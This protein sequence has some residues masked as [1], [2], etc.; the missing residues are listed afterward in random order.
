MLFRPADNAARMREGASRMS[1]VAPDENLFIKGVV[2]AVLENADMVPP[3]GK[4]ALYLRPLLLGTGPILGLG[5]APSFTFTVYATP[6]GSYFKVCSFFAC[7]RPLYRN[8]PIPSADEAQAWS[9]KIFICISMFQTM[10]SKKVP[11][12]Y[13]A[14]LHWSS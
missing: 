6:V 8:Q 4:G 2:G 5:T 1:M 3:A 7:I 10:F 13:P 11:S 9:R 12:S 14:L